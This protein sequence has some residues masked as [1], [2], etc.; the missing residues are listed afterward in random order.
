MKRFLA[1]IMAAFL[2]VSSFAFA[3]AQLTDAER[4]AVGMS[5]A[6][7]STVD[8]YGNAVTDE[9]LNDAVCTVINEW[10]TWCDPCVAELPHFQELHEHY[11]ATPEADVQILASVFVSVSCTPASARALIEQHGYTFTNLLEDEILD[12]VFRTVSGV[13]ST[14]IVDRHGNV[15]A[16]VEGSFS[17][18]EQLQGFVDAWYEILLSEETSITP[19]DVDN[20]GN[21]SISDAVTVMRMAMGLVSGG[22]TD[23]A[24]VNGNGSVDMSDA[25]TVM[26]MAMG[27]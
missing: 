25:V 21:V 26:R 18:V 27:L 3:S 24:D 10:A 6:G 12:S 7:F 17:S 8:L 11:S 9:I 22:N 15:R 19:G 13:P 1:I 23:A 20:D 2:A 14:L 4:N 5:I 16:H